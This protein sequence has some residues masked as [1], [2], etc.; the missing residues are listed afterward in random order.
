ML[1]RLDYLVLIATL[2]GETVRIILD[3]EVN[4]SYISLRLGNKLIHYRYKKDEPYLLTIAN[5]KLVDYDNR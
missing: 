5:G 2:Q 4:R 3:L 1:T